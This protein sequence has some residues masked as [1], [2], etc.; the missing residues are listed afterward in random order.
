MCRDLKIQ[1]Q[2]SKSKAKYEVGNFCTQYGLP[3]IAPSKRKLREKEYPRK[4][5]P[6]SIIA[7][8]RS[9]TTSAKMISIRRVRNP[10]ISIRSM[11]KEKIQHKKHSTRSIANVISVARKVIL[12]KSLD[13]KLKL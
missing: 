8:I 9:P 4:E 3:S 5:Q 2:A 13:L 12:G 11:V 10:K 7:V 6:P 1:S